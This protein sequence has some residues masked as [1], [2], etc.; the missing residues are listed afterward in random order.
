MIDKS[1]SQENEEV[2]KTEKV[3]KIGTRGSALAMTQ[4][5]LVSD[6]LKVKFP[7][8]DFRLVSM[9]TKGDRE[10]NRALLEFGGKA[11][12]V[13]EFEE[14]ILD[15]RIDMAVHSAKD[16]PT[17]IMVGLTIAGVLPRACPQDVL[18]CRQGE[19]ID[20]SSELVIGTSSLRRQYQIK[21]L[22]PNSVCKKLRGNVTT[23]LDKLRAKEFDCI[24]L[25][26]AGIERL[27]LNTCPDLTYDYLP[28]E[29]MTPAACQG[30]IAIET[31]EQGL[32]HDMANAI[33]DA[34]TYRQLV[35]ERKVLNTI[36]AGC[37]EPVGVYST[38]DGD[39][40]TLTIYRGPEMSKEKRSLASGKWQELDEI[41]KEITH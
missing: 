3:I 37:H 14:A 15:G 29:T 4:A 19:R 12:F 27:G 40:L 5:K 36:G 34:N 33:N 30:I 11:V 35:C 25:A 7:D 10:Q 1:R 2:N 26:A 8:Y 32:A 9:S 22:Y 38:L 39:D 16:M 20:K 24:I 31:K 17:E 41:I 23:R 21:E 6:A 13:E 28:V 18:I